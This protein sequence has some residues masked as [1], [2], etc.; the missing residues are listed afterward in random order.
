[1]LLLDIFCVGYGTQVAGHLF[2]NSKFILFYLHEV[3]SYILWEF[4]WNFIFYTRGIV[5]LIRPKKR[6]VL[7][8]RLKKRIIFNKIIN[9]TANDVY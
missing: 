1:M 2:K 3:H 5:R 6:M 8:I 7:T 9:F 4:S